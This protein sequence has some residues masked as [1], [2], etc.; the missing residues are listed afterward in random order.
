MYAR[1]SPDARRDLDGVDK[2]LF[3]PAQA[4]RLIQRQRIHL[5]SPVFHHHS[6]HN[7]PYYQHQYDANPSVEFLTF[8][9]VNAN[10]D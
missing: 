8:L 6:K 9:G 3:R 1:F 10:L 7:T 2:S 4:L 5:K